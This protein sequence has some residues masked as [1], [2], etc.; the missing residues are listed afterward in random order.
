MSEIDIKKDLEII[1]KD[2]LI[3]PIGEITLEREIQGNPSNLNIKFRKQDGK[4][5]KL[6]DTISLKYKGTPAFKG[7]IFV[8]EE[9]EDDLISIKA[10]D[11]TRYLKNTH[12]MLIKNKTATAVIKELAQVF[13]LKTGE[14]IDTKVDIAI[15]QKLI[16]NQSLF[17]IIKDCLE[18]TM[19]ANGVARQRIPEFVLYD[20]YGELTLNEISK[21]ESQV[22][23]D[24][25]NII[26]YTLNN[27]IDNETYNRIYIYHKDDKSKALEQYK[28]SDDEKVKEWGVLQK[29]IDTQR[30]SVDK[31]KTYAEQLLKYYGVP[32]KEFSIKTI[33]NDIEVRGGTKIAVVFNT[34]NQEIKSYFI[35]K[36]V[37]HKFENGEYIMDLNLLGVDMK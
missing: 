24:K 30:I 10:Y 23:L 12:T 37:T 27:D 4:N 31:A 13:L 15:E 36:K 34:N 2:T 28:V 7:Y 17:E 35:V 32:K 20:K 5:F 6:G 16:E 14:L 9:S 11:Q 21:M 8:I 18:Q 19:L 22:V 26:S 25:T 29:T 1:V 3:E 33:A